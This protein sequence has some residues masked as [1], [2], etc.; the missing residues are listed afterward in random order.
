MRRRRGGPSKPE[1][2]QAWAARKPG[3]S[4]EGSAL[5]LPA[6]QPFFLPRTI[7]PRHP[8]PEAPHSCG[9]ALALATLPPSGYC[10]GCIQAPGGLSMLR[11]GLVLALSIVLLAG[12]RLPAED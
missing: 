4:R 5:P 9:L 12:Q 11:H 1:G 8:V 3:A 6:P 7:R 10:Q 2:G